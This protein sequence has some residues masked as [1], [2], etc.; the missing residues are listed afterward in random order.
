MP[1]LPNK[2]L[3][4]AAIDGV[5][6]QP[7]AQRNQRQPPGVI[8]DYKRHGIASRSGTVESDEA[9]GLD[10]S[11]IAGLSNWPIESSHD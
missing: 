11:G 4:F 1:G 3:I 10:C 5:V 7:L 9:D 6:L 8:I 2:I